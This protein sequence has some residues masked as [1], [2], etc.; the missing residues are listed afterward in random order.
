MEDIEMI[1]SKKREA[2]L[3]LDTLYFDDNLEENDIIRNE[4][5]TFS[6]RI[7]NLNCSKIV[8][9]KSFGQMENIISMTS[10][11]KALGYPV[12]NISIIV[13]N[14]KLVPQMLT[15]P[16]EIIK[17]FNIL[18]KSIEELKAKYGDEYK[19]HI[20]EIYDLSITE[21]EKQRD[22]LDSN[23]SIDEM[24]DKLKTGFEQ[25]KDS[26]PEDNKR[27]LDLAIQIYSSSLFVSLNRIASITDYKNKNG[28]ELI[29]EC[30]KNEDFKHSFHERFRYFNS[31]LN[32]AYDGTEKAILKRFEEILDFSSEEKL[33]E[34]L[35]YV[36][37]IIDAHKDKLVIPEDIFVYRGFANSKP[38][39]NMSLAE[40]DIISTSLKRSVAIEFSDKTGF[41]GKYRYMNYI[42]VQKGTP[43]I[44]PINKQAYAQKEVIFLGSAVELEKIGY[45]CR[46]AEVNC[47]ARTYIMS[48]KERVI[49]KEDTQVEGKASK[50]VGED[51][52]KDDDRR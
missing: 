21:K 7:Y 14:R 3:D 34:S 46:D 52:I 26:L 38:V 4:D 20:D 51:S 11:L 44:M 1:D 12:E 24:Y 9:L 47:N 31:I 40:S 43:Y 2:L 29:T 15:V 23:E 32:S 28:A 8:K 50:I 27:K 5:G 41:S 16:S 17:Y 33:A 19:D 18:K 25:Y 10:R 6:C 22:K 30:D 36:L 42:L 39:D 49:E 13:D 45:N 37:D 48:P 35:K